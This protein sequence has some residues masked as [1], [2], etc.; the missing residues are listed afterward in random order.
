M[1]PALAPLLLGALL[2]WAGAGKLA[3]RTAPE[4]DSALMRLLH[5]TRR[6]TLAVRLLGA[7]EL[8]LAAGL[9]VRP[10]WT[11]P[12]YAATVLGLGFLGYLAWARAAAPESS[13][14]CTS[15]RHTPITARSFVRAGLVVAGG[16]AGTA[17]DRPWW[18]VVAERPVAAGVVVA[19]A[20]VV[21]AAL[22][23]DLD[24]R[25]LLPLRRARLRLLGH[26]LPEPA[27][28]PVPV[29][30]SV[31]L[32]EQ[33][34]AWH[35][36]APIVRSALLEHWDQDGWRFLRFA[37]MADARPVTVVFALPSDATAQTAEPAIRVTMV[38]TE[39]PEVLPGP[40]LATRSLR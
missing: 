21:V 35:A 33:S 14:G 39:R 2:G 5:D 1:L 32:L 29:A 16:L 37:G 11:L 40:V 12:G 31:E 30:A 24:E 25:W 22:A 3:D 18:T 23:G 9:L 19:A 36:A 6:V 4:P 7:V 27:G 15:S 13:C 34:L 26:P 8:G 20:I 28:G 38:A 17:A 10:M